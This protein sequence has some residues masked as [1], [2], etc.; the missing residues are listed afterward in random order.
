MQDYDFPRPF[1]A[2]PELAEK[3]RERV[4]LLSELLVKANVRPNPVLIQPRGLASV[5]EGLQYMYEGKVR[6]CPRISVSRSSVR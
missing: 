3:G 6:M 2:S 4:R 5:A 1:T